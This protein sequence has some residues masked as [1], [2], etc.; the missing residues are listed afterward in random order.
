MTINPMQGEFANGSMMGW[1]IIDASCKRC[2]WKPWSCNQSANSLSGRSCGVHSL[3][4]EIM[5]IDIK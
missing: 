2:E 1:K 3:S 5:S 4:L